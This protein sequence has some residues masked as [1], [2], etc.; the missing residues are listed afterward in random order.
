MI[1]QNPLFTFSI[2]ILFVFFLE[3]L[4]IL[5][6]LVITFCLYRIYNKNVKEYDYKIFDFDFNGF[7]I[8]TYFLAY[9]YIIFWYKVSYINKT[10]DLKPVIIFIKNLLS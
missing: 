10:T 4:P 7:C 2:K 3:I 9:L 1:L 5:I 8:I 6:M